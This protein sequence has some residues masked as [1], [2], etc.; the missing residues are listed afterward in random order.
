MK[1]T[2]NNQQVKPDAIPVFDKAFSRWWKSKKTQ[3]RFHCGQYG[4]YEIAYAA[5]EF[6]KNWKQDNPYVD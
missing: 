6:G 3:R 4:E 1:P 2:N 5:T